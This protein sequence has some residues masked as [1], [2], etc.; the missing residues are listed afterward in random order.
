MYI[1]NRLH[2][3]IY[4]VAA[5]GVMPEVGQ[6]LAI[7]NTPT[8]I[9]FVEQESSIELTESGL[10]HCYLP[11]GCNNVSDIVLEIGSDGESYEANN[12]DVIDNTTSIEEILTSYKEL[13][14]ID[15]N[16]SD[17]DIF[18]VP[19]RE[20]DSLMCTA[21]KR[22]CALKRAPLSIYANKFDKAHDLTNLAKAIKT[23]TVTEKKFLQVAD[24]M[25]VEYCLIVQDKDNSRHKMGTDFIVASPGFKFDDELFRVKKAQELVDLFNKDKN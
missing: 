21:V 3:K 4:Y 13:P 15:M 23:G 1:R 11:E 14:D 2:N 22:I 17:D 18:V 6:V 9:P 12:V 19:E 8:Y 25:D 20:D 5:P 16:Y 7:G 10:T 24:I